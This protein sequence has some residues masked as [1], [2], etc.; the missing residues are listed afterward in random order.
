VARIL[1]V[2]DEPAIRAIVRRILEPAGYE[3]LEAED[4]GDA[5]RV[6][7]REAVHLV[8]TDI[9]MPG[10]DGITT[11]RRVRRRWPELPI[12]AMSGGSQAGELSAAAL[13]LGARRS[14][15]K[16]FTLAEMLTAVQTVLGEIP[17]EDL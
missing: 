2:D 14:I 10:E 4:G 15:S 7:N 16:P 1:V 13:A 12:I 5:I 9:F 3:V 11:I 6:L 8:I 17:K